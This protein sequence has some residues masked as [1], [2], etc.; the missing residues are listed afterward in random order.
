LYVNTL[1][2]GKEVAY[3]KQ[4]PVASVTTA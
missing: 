2:C 1:V 4:K 3:V